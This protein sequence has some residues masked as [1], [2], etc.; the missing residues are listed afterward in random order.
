M[1]KLKNKN[2]FN[3]F[4]I[5]RNNTS[6]KNIISL[7]GERIIDLLVHTPISINLNLISK[8]IKVKDI[9]NTAIVDLIVIKHEKNY[10]RRSPYKVICKNSYSQIVEILFFNMK[11]I[12]LKNYLTIQHQYRVTGK[13]LF[14]NGKFQIIHPT[15]VLNKKD[16]NDF[17]K[18]EPIYDLSR[19]NINKK[20][21]RKLIK[22]NVENIDFSNF[23]NEWIEKE[24]MNKSW[25]SFKE[26]ILQIHFPKN[27]NQVRMLE[28][29]RKRLAFDELLSSYLTFYELKKKTKR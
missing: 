12:Q 17:E 20:I 27:I 19:K 15:N 16:I 25:S 29:N 26:S 1:N 24:F 9:D 4:D 3:N 2:I 18:Y 14:K 5:K 23:P 7:F 13:I 11:E 22:S 10:N 6:I 21:F 8:E 28:N